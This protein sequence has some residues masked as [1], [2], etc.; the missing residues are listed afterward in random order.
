MNPTISDKILVLGIDGMD[1]RLTRKYIDTGDMPATKELLARGAG[2]E[3]L[4]MLGGMPCITPPMWTTLATGCYPNVHGITHYFRCMMP[5]QGYEW[6]G[7]N[8]DSSFN[9]AEPLWNVFVE[10][11]KKTLVWHWPGSSWPPTSDSPLLHVIDGTQPAAVNA[12]IA[13]VE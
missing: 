2:R 4:V 1:P 12:G 8:L 3:D 5:E 10:A 7:Y 9:K 11:G 6:L 13:E